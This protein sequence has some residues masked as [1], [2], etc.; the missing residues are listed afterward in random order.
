[1]LGMATFLVADELEDC[2]FN[3][4]TTGQGSAYKARPLTASQE[5][6][7]LVAQYRGD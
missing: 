4:L 1:M 2:G 3:V 7:T 6:M 5:A